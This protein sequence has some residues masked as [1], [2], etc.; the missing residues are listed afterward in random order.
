MQ[1]QFSQEETTTSIHLQQY[2]ERERAGGLPKVLPGFTRLIGLGAS[3]GELRDNSVPVPGL[4]AKPVAY[5]GILGAS[6]ICP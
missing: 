3:N 1:L 4:A 2:L 5:S 6:G